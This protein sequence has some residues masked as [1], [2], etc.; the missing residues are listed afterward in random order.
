MGSDTQATFAPPLPVPVNLEAAKT[1]VTIPPSSMRT[2]RS[3][4]PRPA[5]PSNV[6]EY[7]AQF[8]PQVQ[9]ILQRVREAV[10][11]GAPEAVEV[12]SY[13]MPALKQDGVLVYFAAFKGH[14]GLYPPIKGDPR[15]EE[16]ALPYAGEKGNLRFL[17][18]EPI[19]YKLITGLTRL[20]AKQDSMRKGRRRS[21]AKAAKK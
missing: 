10:R 2:E 9:A 3:M 4:T 13:R 1:G 8:E 21:P 18:S 16:Q 19:P 7:I 11:A 17:Y 12:I 5:T 20:R 15:L 6:D 14:I